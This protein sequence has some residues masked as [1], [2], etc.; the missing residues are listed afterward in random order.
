[1]NYNVLVTDNFK[2]NS[3]RLIKKYKSF[4]N[5]INDLIDNLE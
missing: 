1:M 5:E 4:K 3:E 2:H